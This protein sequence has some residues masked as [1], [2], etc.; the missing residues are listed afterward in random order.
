VTIGLGF[1]CADG[2]VLLSDTQMSNGYMK[3]YET[4]LLAYPLQGS[5][6]VCGVTLTYAGN[7]TTWKKFRDEFESA[8]HD[9]QYDPTA[10][11]I[12]KTVSEIL[13]NMRPMLFNPHG[14]PDLYLLCGAIQDGQAPL[15]LRSQADTAHRVLDG[16]DVIG[17]GDT[18]VIRY[19]SK[20]L[21]LRNPNFTLDIGKKVGAYV[22]LQAKA[23]VDGCG[24][25]TDI[26]CIHRHGGIQVSSAWAYTYEQELGKIEYFIQNLLQVS[27]NPA[28]K[29]QDIQSVADRFV[30]SLEEVMPRHSN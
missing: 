14:E 13:C 26:V 25:D 24:G 2:I 29:R 11:N 16:F 9:N 20:V 8:V 27:C 5:K 21:F 17:A 23:F 1:S 22:V 12:E 30:V 18:S 4:K 15:L 6:G 7:P 3:F 19:L 28:S 10:N